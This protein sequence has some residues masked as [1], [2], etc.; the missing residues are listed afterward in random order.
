MIN[1]KIISKPK[2]NGS[3]TGINTGGNTTGTATAK[4]A[5]H[6]L[7]ADQADK[8]KHA[9][10][11]DL[12]TE[13]AHAASAYDLDADSPARSEF[14]SRLADDVAAGRITFEKGLVALFNSEFKKGATFG[15]Y[16]QG[17]VGA[18]IDEAGRLEAESIT[19]RGYLKVFEL[20]YNR[21]NAL[22]GNT[23][24]ADV[25]T[26]DSIA[27]SPD[28]SQ[29]LTMRK[30]WDGDFTAFQPGDVV[31]SYIN[32]L[33]NGQASEYYK[34]WAWV[35]SV[36]RAANTLTVVPY[37]DSMVPAG[38]N[39]SLAASQIITRWGNNIE[40]NAYTWANPDYSAVI[41]KR[42]DNDYV[43][44]RQSTFYISCE[45]G[46]IVE[47]MGVNKPILEAGNYGT[48]LGKM[49]DGLLDPATQELVNKDHPY[50][51]ARG[52][53]VQD[54]IRMDYTGAI[55][56]TGNYRGTWRAAT[57]A[58]ATDYYR[59]LPGTYDFV[60][61]K[62]DLWQCVTTGNTDEPSATTGN[63][64]NMTDG[65]PLPKLDVWQI[66][67][68]TD[69]VTLRYEG[70]KVT[71]MPIKVSCSVLLTSTEDGTVTYTSNYDL[72]QKGVHLY[73]S[74]DGADWKEF[75]IGVSEPLDLENETGVIETEGDKPE[76]LTLGGDDVSA[77]QI[78]D[79]IY[80][81]LRN[82]ID[83]LART[84]V[85]VVKDGEK[86]DSGPQ[87]RD[88]LMVYPDGYFSADKTYTATAETAPV[89]MY[90]LTKDQHRFYVLKRGKSYSAADMP[91]NR[92]TPAGDVAYGGEDA[93]WQVFDNFN[94][95]FADIIMAD[96]AKLSSAV[97]YGDWLISQ[98]G[99]LTNGTA[100]TEYQK[101]KTG[102]FIP[103]YAVNFKTGEISANKA[104]IKGVIE[105]IAGKIA[106]Y[107]INDDSITYGDVENLDLDS[108][109]KAIVSPKRFLIQDQDPDQNDSY[110]RI[111]LGRKADPNNTN[112]FGCVAFVYKNDRSNDYFKAF[113]PALRIIAR[114]NYGCLV[115]LQ[116]KGAVITDEG[117]ISE[118]G[119]IATATS[120]AV[121]VTRL[122]AWEGTVWAIENKIQNDYLVFLPTL[123]SIQQL[124]NNTTGPF[125]WRVKFTVLLNSNR[126]KLA[127]EGADQDSIKIYSGTSATTNFTASAGKF[128][129]AWLIHTAT[130]TY[131]QIREI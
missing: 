71:I 22:E 13:A 32:N 131:W 53:I 8:A 19:A 49:P 100:S 127:L 59:S 63:W 10:L 123:S 129:E 91:D 125:I 30:R 16:V 5:A 75:I 105:A 107:T 90:G 15:D 27:D 17:N 50:L 46:N 98:Q 95:V 70:D 122:R 64:V 103:H 40:A 94:A 6:A 11:A 84:T 9:E 124:L 118:N 36:D 99:V 86:G 7:R 92:K 31:Y 47:L 85:P 68:N 88:G 93:R 4:D 69:I 77:S 54:L 60:T 81:E 116:S 106:G 109:R 26:I 29:V 56:R 80:F 111:A 72:A 33:N 2:S 89:V 12:A 78:G 101:F 51:F 62:G 120:A 14:L 112:D 55:T 21:L 115:G 104:T 83:V 74:L 3:A 42:G 23:S 61:W 97:F 57:A 113:Y 28:G 1:V 20:I 121:Q 45:D 58:S 79:R 18:A 35:K 102:E 73:Y 130:E 24:F 117:A 25:G 67:P 108:T 126:V 114:S 43:N 52:I 76:A 39:H 37:D 41:Q 48:V 96:F 66:L 128:Y 65:Q 38:V 119:R 82:D 44:V 87:G 110:Y 34:A